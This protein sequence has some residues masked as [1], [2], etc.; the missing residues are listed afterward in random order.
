MHV[1]LPEKVKQKAPIDIFLSEHAKT[2]MR[3]IE[4]PADNYIVGKK[5]VQ[6][7]F[8][9]MAIIAMIKRGEKFLTPNGSTEIE[10]N[11]IL[12]VLSDSQ[13]GMDQVYECLKIE[14]TEVM[15]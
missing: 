11:D 1:A 9:K 12:I 13:S 14:P 5:I 4:I 15:D 7:E 3:E 6:L 2:A 10:P 8:P